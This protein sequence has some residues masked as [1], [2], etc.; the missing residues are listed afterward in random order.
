ML[1]ENGEKVTSDR[2][3]LRSLLDSLKISVDNPVC[4][5][6]QENSKHFIRGKAKDKYKFFL[7]ATEI[8]DVME[9][10]KRATPMPRTSDF[11]T[12]S[13]SGRSWNRSRAWR[14]TRNGSTRK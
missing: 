10:I 1:N 14:R 6:D 9:R 12:R 7:R 4:V 8:Q 5:L 3:E 2:K 13:T 11:P